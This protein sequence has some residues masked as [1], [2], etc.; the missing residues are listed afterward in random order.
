M[1]ALAVLMVL[2]GVMVMI[3]FVE[4]DKP[5]SLQAQ[6]VATNY[7]MF[8]NEVYRYVFDGHMAAGDVPTAALTLPVGYVPLRPWR[9]RL[10]SGCLYVWGTASSD[11][12]EATRE[13]FWG[14]KAVGRASAGFMVPDG[15]TPVPG[16]V[17]E[18]SLVSVTG[19]Q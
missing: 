6:A 2:M 12:I 3:R 4:Q 9:A 18:G 5:D 16:F 8:R 13:L 15:V 7:A 17:P 11:E 10:D 14:S 1:K 19:T